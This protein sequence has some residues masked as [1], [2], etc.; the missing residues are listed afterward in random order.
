MEKLMGSDKLRPHNSHYYLPLNKAKVQYA[1]VQGLKVELQEV[2]GVQSKEKL[3]YKGNILNAIVNK[4]VV[5]IKTLGRILNT[6]PM[7]I[8]H[9]MQRQWDSKVSSSSQWALLTQLDDDLMSL[10]KQLFSFL[11]IGGRMRQWFFQIRAMS[12]RNE[13]LV[14]CMKNICCLKHVRMDFFFVPI[15]AYKPNYCV[16]N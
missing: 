12:Q 7:N 6:N 15:L 2:K 13:L 9:A 8:T 4:D 5:G 10:M 1:L 11:W 3:P 16:R 14:R